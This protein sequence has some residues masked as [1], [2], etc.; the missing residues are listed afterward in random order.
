[1]ATLAADLR[2]TNYPFIL[3][4]VEGAEDFLLQPHI[5]GIDRA[6]M[7][8]ELHEGAVPGITE[9]LESRFDKSH[10]TQVIQQDDLSNHHPPP[11]IN[12]F[13]RWQ[14][15]RLIKED[16]KEPMTW[17]HLLPRREPMA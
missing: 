17:M 16:R 15:S 13:V 10:L 8:V 3:M 6:E 5:A 12:P 2:D 14:W 1:M 11:D 4:D 7:L 9:R